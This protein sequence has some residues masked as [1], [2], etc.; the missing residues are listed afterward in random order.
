MKKPRPTPEPEPV[1][2]HDS[3]KS[4][5]TNA[6]GEDMYFCSECKK[7]WSEKKEK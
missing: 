6:K 3:A 5:G 4:I 7:I 2:S 1:C